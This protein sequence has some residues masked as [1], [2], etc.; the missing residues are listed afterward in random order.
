VSEG[1]TPSNHTTFT[2]SCKVAGKRLSLR[3]FGHL[4]ADP[5]FLPAKLRC[6]FL[7]EI[8]GLEYLADL[9]L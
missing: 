6:E 8:V 7:S 3:V 2:L 4:L 1:V 5:L 9:D